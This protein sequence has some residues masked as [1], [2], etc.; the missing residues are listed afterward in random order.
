MLQSSWLSVPMSAQ[1]AEHLS[2]P[3]WVGSSRQ[4]NQGGV[5]NFQLGL[6]RGIIN[7]MLKLTHLWLQYSSAC[8]YQNNRTYLWQKTASATD[9]TR[10]AHFVGHTVILKKYPKNWALVRLLGPWFHMRKYF[11]L[12]NGPNDFPTFWISCEI[13]LMWYNGPKKIYCMGKM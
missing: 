8:A 5:M 4:H 7:L 11:I 10:E 13:I 9:T 1:W 3:R 12:F 2:F 6:S